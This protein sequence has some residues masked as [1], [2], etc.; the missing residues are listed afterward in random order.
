MAWRGGDVGRVLHR[1]RPEVLLAQ[2]AGPL[3]T[4]PEG[5]LVAVQK[6]VDGEQGSPYDKPDVFLHFF[7]CTYISVWYV[8]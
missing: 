1:A 4:A 8:F 3:G 7:T 2:L 5:L 6:R